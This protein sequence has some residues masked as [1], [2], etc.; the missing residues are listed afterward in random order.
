MQLHRDLCYS[1]FAG[2]SQQ[3]QSFNFRV[4]R[5]TVCKI[6]REVCTAIWTALQPTYLSTPSTPEQWRKL[7][8]RF[9]EQWDFPNVLGAVD[10]KHIAMECPKKGGSLYFNYKSF[11]STVLMAMCDA[12]YNFIYIDIG[13]YGRDNDAS[14]FNQSACFERFQNGD[15]NLPEPTQEGEETLPYV[16]LGDD[17][18]PLRTWLLKP[19]SG[20]NLCNNE[21]V[22]NYRLSRGR[23]TIENAFGILAARWRIFRKPIRAEVCTVDR[24][25]EA[26]VCLH[27]YLGLTENASYIPAGFVDTETAN[28]EITPGDWRLEVGRGEALGPIGRLAAN[29]YGADAK[30]TRLAFCRYV[31]SQQ[32]SVPWQLAHVTNTG[33]VHVD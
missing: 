12:D 19:F 8:D 26:C 1:V 29:N 10:G 21:M 20:R 16:I 24:I 32:G 30:E 9:R 5:S 25:T 14:I 33:R 13:S 2:D 15:V 7:S 31:N 23:R 22:F 6:I 27:N 3:S 28:G 11:H 18:F 17:A 4:G